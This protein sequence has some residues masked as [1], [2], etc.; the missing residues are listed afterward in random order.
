[1]NFMLCALLSNFFL[2]F[3]IPLLVSKQFLV[4]KDIIIPIFFIESISFMSSFTSSFL[5]ISVLPKLGQPVESSCVLN[6][7]VQREHKK[8]LYHFFIEQLFY[9]N[10]AFIHPVNAFHVIVVY[11]HDFRLVCSNNFPFVT[12]NIFS[13]TYWLYPDTF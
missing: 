7:H 8:G 5:F 2:T 4:I 12:L 6:S 10:F 3:Y 1:M 9:C 11:L 13:S